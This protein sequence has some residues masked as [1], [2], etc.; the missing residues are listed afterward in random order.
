MQIDTLFVTV[1]PDRA[2]KHFT[3][4]DPVAKVAFGHV[5]TRAT[6]ATRA[7]AAS[8]KALLDKLIA[9]APFDMKGSEFKADFEKAC[10]NKKPLALRAAPKEPQA[11]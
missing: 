5:A 10:K 3:A 11:Q 8:A 6:R 1:R 4:Y 9:E 7:T 2:I